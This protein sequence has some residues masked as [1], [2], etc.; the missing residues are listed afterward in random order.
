MSCL[1]EVENRRYELMGEGARQS[2]AAAW[3]TSNQV[4]ACR[5]FVTGGCVQTEA[6]AHT[7]L[8]RALLFFGFFDLRECG[9]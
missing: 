4:L 9:G 1:S 7:S 5:R 8:P 3:S 2:I 6:R